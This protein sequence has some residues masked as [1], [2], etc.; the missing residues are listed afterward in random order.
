MF[1]PPPLRPGD[2]EL[3]S[4][5]LPLPLP[6]FPLQGAC[7]AEWGRGGATPHTPALRPPPPLCTACHPAPRPLPSVTHGC[8]TC[9]VAVSIYG[10]PSAHMHSPT[11]EKHASKAGVGPRR[12]PPPPPVDKTLDNQNRQSLS[13]ARPRA[14]QHMSHARQQGCV[15]RGGWGGRSR[16]PSLC[17][18]TVSLTPSLSFSGIRNRQ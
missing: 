12:P 18:A 7:R 15:G 5:T 16:A 1:A 3:L 14:E 2:A 13:G 4:K 17:P 8:V 10:A 9:E 6:K 11:S